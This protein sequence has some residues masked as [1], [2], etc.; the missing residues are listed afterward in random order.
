MGD[1]RRCRRCGG[2]AIRVVRVNA[3]GRE[4]RLGMYWFVLGVSMFLLIGS[5][6][7]LYGPSRNHLLLALPGFILVVV[8]V[9]C[10]ILVARMPKRFQCENAHTWQ[11]SR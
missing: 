9:L 8:S 1:Q 6:F 10:L 2:E 3:K 7:G 5:F 4:F 11:Q